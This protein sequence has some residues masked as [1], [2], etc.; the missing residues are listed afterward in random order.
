MNL[1][2]LPSDERKKSEGRDYRTFRQ[3]KMSGLQKA[4]LVRF[5]REISRLSL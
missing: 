3:V 1:C 5:G 2:R 4:T